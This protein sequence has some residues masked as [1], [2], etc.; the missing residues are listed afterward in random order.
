MACKSEMDQ[1]RDNNRRSSHRGAEEEVISLLLGNIES[2][3]FF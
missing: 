2:C 3:A 1:K